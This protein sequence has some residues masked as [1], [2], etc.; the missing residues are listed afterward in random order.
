MILQFFN[1]NK[2]TVDNDV[3]GIV[4]MNHKKRNY[5]YLNARRVFCFVLK[6]LKI[7]L[8]GFGEGKWNKRFKTYRHS[9]H[10]I[11]YTEVFFVY[12]RL[13]REKIKSNKSFENGGSLLISFDIYSLEIDPFRD[14]EP[15]IVLYLRI[16][17]FNIVL[18]QQ[19]KKFY[20]FC[21]FIFLHIYKRSSGWSLEMFFCSSPLFD[22]IQYVSPQ[23][24][25]LCS[26]PW[27]MH[28]WTLVPLNNAS[29]GQGIFWTTLPLDV[30]LLDDTPH[31]KR[32][33]KICPIPG[34]HHQDVSPNDVSPTENSWMFHPLN[35]ASLWYCVP[36]QCVPPDLGPRRA[37][38]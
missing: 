36:D 27:T 31:E 12:S 23:Q 21:T 33:P 9:F 37:W 5:V 24:S 7:Y 22:D 29:L 2:N 26:I 16:L 11:F 4:Y 14:P 3:Q 6:R 1:L 18:Y 28:P 35:K 10:L 25:L 32:I 15:A 38:N 34:L 20:R 19:G 30:A 13:Q 17:V 8:Y